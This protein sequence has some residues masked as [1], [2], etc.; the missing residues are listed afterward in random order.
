[1]AGTKLT[2]DQLHDVLLGGPTWALGG[3][4]DGRL[5]METAFKRERERQGPCIVVDRDSDPELLAAL[6]ELGHC[7]RLAGEGRGDPEPLWELGQDRSGELAVALLLSPG[8]FPAVIKA[9]RLT[10]GTE[11]FLGMTGDPERLRQ[12]I[13]AHHAWTASR[14]ADER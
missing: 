11:L 13:D 8:G 14:P 10:D 9:A 7:L 6:R 12:A 4:R 5:R 2:S 1:M 3:T